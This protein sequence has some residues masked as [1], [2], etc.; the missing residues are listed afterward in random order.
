MSDF[1]RLLQ[2]LR[3]FQ[4]RVV[5]L[6]GCRSD[7]HGNPLPGAA[8]FAAAARLTATARTGSLQEVRLYFQPLPPE[9]AGEEESALY[10]VSVTARAKEQRFLVEWQPERQSFRLLDRV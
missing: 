2:R 7:E 3:P 10:T 4:G 1:E 6:A 9:L 8:S 5:A